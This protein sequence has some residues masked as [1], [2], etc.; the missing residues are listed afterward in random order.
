[1]NLIT[2]P[3]FE[4]FQ[5]GAACPCPGCAAERAPAALTG[6]PRRRG[7]TGASGVRAVLAV[8]AAATSVLGAAP[9][10]PPAFA[11][12]EPPGVAAHD[13]RPGAEGARDANGAYGP[14][15]PQA[16]AVRR[17]ATG[18]DEAKAR[19]E[20]AGTRDGAAG[21]P[22]LGRGA[23]GPDEAKARREA[24][25]TRD[26]AAGAPALGRGA[27]GAAEAQARREAGFA[28]A[29]REAKREG[30]TTATRPAPRSATRPSPRSAAPVRPAAA[31]R[32]PSATQEGEHPGGSEDPDDPSEGPRTP[33]GSTEPLHTGGDGTAVSPGTVTREEIIDRARTWLDA[34]VPYSMS[35]YRSDGY[36]QDCSGFVSMAWDLRSNQ[37]TG[38][39]ASFGE[40]ITK[41]E[42]EP[43]DMLLFHNAANPQD[44]SHV[45]LFGGWADAAHTKYTAYEQTPPHTRSR[46]TPYAYWTNSSQYVPYR[47]KNLA[48][49][50]GGPES[51]AFP[52]TAAFGPGKAGAR[53]TRLGEL[54]VARGAGRYYRVGPGP[55]WT[56]ADRRATAAFQRAQG[57]RGAGAD[58]IPG[59]L[60]WA[61]LLGG[62]GG[63]VR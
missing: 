42:L 23:T 5:P 39:L 13:A 16:P 20:A 50:S 47:A 15:A 7:R 53:V 41:D 30:G 21:A 22:A 51:S 17:E 10:A 29:P 43:G 40:R 1:M 2:G 31:P 46:T 8:A 27:T 54:L 55:R 33:Q 61:Y 24:A 48:S 4:E 26:G 19:R 32:E 12:P 56:E 35:E 38:S 3:V 18:P 9:L 14:G 6:S 44:G 28:T 59:P 25:G 52:G 49:G 60:T 45:T 57:W 11:A 36:R 34:K 62:R 58:G 37:W 63:D